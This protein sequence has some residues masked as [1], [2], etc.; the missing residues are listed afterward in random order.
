[1]ITATAGILGTEIRDVMVCAVNQ[2]PNE[3]FVEETRRIGAALWMIQDG[4][5]TSAEH[6]GDDLAT[7][8]STSLSLAGVRVRGTV[9]TTHSVI[10]WA[11]DGMVRFV[12]ARHDLERS[13][14]HFR[15]R[16]AEVKCR[17]SRV[18]GMTRVAIF[19]TAHRHRRHVFVGGPGI[20][21]ML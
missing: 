20:E 19:L 3:P 21:P 13:T 17:E 2:P 10:M 5:V 16:R 11:Q 15:S 12:R 18:E 6:A 1:M 14:V 7:G 9:A 4:D 8:I